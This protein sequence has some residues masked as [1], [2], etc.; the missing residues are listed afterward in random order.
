MGASYAFA[1]TAL[2]EIGVIFAPY[3]FA[4]VLI[5]RI[6][7]VHITQIGHCQQAGNIGIVHQQLVPES[8]DFEGIYFT[9]FRVIINRTLLQGGFYLLGQI[10]TFFR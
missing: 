9:V 5:N 6:V 7:Y 8:I 3:E 1:G 2:E 10:G 4:G